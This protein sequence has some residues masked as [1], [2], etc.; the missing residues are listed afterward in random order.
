MHH[1]KYHNIAKKNNKTN[2]I[3]GLSLCPGQVNE[4]S[5][6]GRGVGVKGGVAGAVAASFSNFY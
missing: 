5:G 3:P 6:D 4:W 1:F 2:L